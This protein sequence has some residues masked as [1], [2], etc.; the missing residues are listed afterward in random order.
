MAN[1]SDSLPGN[2]VA[3]PGAGVRFCEIDTG[4]HDQRID[5]Y[6]LRELKGVPKS[7]IYNI[8]RKGEV[9]VNK[10]RVGPD[11]RLQTGDMLRIPPVR[12]AERTPAFIGDKTLAI[13]QNSILYEDAGMLVVNKPAG[14]A[15]H[16]GSG[17]DFGLIEALRKLRPDETGIELVHRL[18][19]DTSGCV[20]L[21]KK[22]SVLKP[23]HEAFRGDGVDKR[24]LALAMGKWPAHL[25]EINAPLNKNELKS[26]ERMVTVHADGKPSVTRFT[27]VE[28]FEQ[29]TLIEAKP[30]TGRTHQ[31]R[32]HAQFAGH[33]L[34]GDS[35]YGRDEDN[36]RLREAGLRRLFLHSASISCFFPHLKRQLKFEAPL[37]PELESVLE[38]L[39]IR[40]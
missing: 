14:I 34:A 10:K 37:P 36:T 9:R 1:G 12:T 24:Y 39:R 19:R 33:A 17:V 32:V 15:V 7:R 20:L 11:Y 8:L 23:L 6:L 18:D 16:G 2:G 22:R 27:V 35:K 29:A 26:G 28:R 40:K 31:I 4:S 13:V 30:V 3:L 21:A 5:N 38:N 25:K